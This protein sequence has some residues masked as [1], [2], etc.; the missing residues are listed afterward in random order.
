VKLD[1][2][3]KSHTIPALSAWP[4]LLCLT[5]P[6]GAERLTFASKATAD[7]VDGEVLFSEPD[8]LLAQLILL[9]EGLGLTCRR[10]EEIAARFLAELM[11]KD[12]KTSWCIAEASGRLGRR[13]PSTKKA[14][15]ASYWRWVELAGS[16]NT[17][18]R[19]RRSLDLS[20][21]LPRCH[22]DA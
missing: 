20:H 11:G 9:P 6:C 2:L 16:R 4:V 7:I 14:R 3:P 15:R 13:T 10:E 18:A 1:R 22:P 8:D 12:T 5:V 17:R 19:V 21:I